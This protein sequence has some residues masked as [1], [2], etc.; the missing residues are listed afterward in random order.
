MRRRLRQ[1]KWFFRYYGWSMA[2]PT[3]IARALPRI[4][5][6]RWS[7]DTKKPAFDRRYGVDTAGLV[8]VAEL[9][10]NDEERTHGNDYEPTPGVGLG[11]VLDELLVDY[12]QF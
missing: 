6:S 8:G 4:R 9:G 2:I 12:R 3:V 11:V 5:R 7:N 10:F 1:A